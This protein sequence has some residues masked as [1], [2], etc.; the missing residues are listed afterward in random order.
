MARARSRKASAWNK[1]IRAA[2]KKGAK[3]MKAA[4]AMAKK[5]YKP[6]SK[7]GKKGKRTMKRSMR[8]RKGKRS[9]KKM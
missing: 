6:K 5:T 9:A 2:Y 1:A 4:V 8:S 3:N 7:G